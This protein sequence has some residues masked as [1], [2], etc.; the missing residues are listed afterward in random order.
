MLEFQK[1]IST[2]KHVW[3]YV[4]TCIVS[5]PKERGFSGPKEEVTGEGKSM[6]N[7]YS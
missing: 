3:E 1:Y 6:L 4:R 2:D 7:R 5:G